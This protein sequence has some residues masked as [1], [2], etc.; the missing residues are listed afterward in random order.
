MNRPQ[1]WDN[2]A[3]SGKNLGMG[4]LISLFELFADTLILLKDTRFKKLSRALLVITLA[5]ACSGITGTLAV[6]TG[7]TSNAAN[8]FS[9][10]A[11]YA[12]TNLTATSSGGSV[13][14]NWTAGLNGNS[15]TVLGGDNGTNATCPA[16]TTPDFYTTTI[17][18][19]S[20][21]TYTDPRSIAAGNTYCYQVQT[22][23]QSWTS[24]Q[25]N[26][27][28]AV[29]VAGPPDP[30]TNL[31]ATPGG[32]NAL[33]NWTAGLNATGYNVLGVANG[34]SSTCPAATSPS[35]SLINST[36]GTSFTDANRA[37]PGGATPSGGMVPQG[38]WYC[39]MVNST[40]GAFTSTGNPIAGVQ[41]GFVVTSVQLINGASTDWVDS[42]DIIVVN[43]N[44]P[45]NPATGPGSTDTVASEA[46]SGQLLIGSTVTSGAPTAGEP[47]KLGI[48][49]GS[50]NSS[51]RFSATYTW[52]NA[53][54]TLTV[55]LGAK[56]AGPA[57]V[58]LNSTTWTFNPTT[59]AANL[60]STA[61]A[62]HI[63]DTNT[64]G[65]NCIPTPTGGF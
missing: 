59:T 22:T 33:L 12:P 37:A 9:I 61:G 47:V 62:N 38:S 15:Y 64:G 3:L 44:Q 20:G 28:V 41:V 6:L 43:F 45:V 8:S 18:I 25:T 24:V 49:T 27:V 10:T 19:T 29:S 7:Q 11:L 51:A 32:R 17:G 21:T 50:F 42:G 48:L 57:N 63:C 58:K 14:L 1:H 13:Q 34:V 35:Y 30:P 2:R 31:T 4:L 60:Q 65:G 46:T 54:K 53:N 40:N 36:T 39:Y 5:L 16:A 52:T 23:Y 55:T 26:P 56:I